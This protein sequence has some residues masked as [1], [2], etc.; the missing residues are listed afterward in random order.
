MLLPTRQQDYAPSLYWLLGSSEI[1]YIEYGCYCPQPGFLKQ[2]IF[3]YN[4]FFI[5]SVLMD[6]LMLLLEVC[7]VYFWKQMIQR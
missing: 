4:Y 7:S 5:D 3:P 2:M 6:V 1:S